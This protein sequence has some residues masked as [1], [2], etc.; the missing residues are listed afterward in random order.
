MLFTSFIYFTIYC[1]C[2][3]FI[4][5]VSLACMFS[6]FFIYFS[7]FCYLF[8]FLLKMRGALLYKPVASSPLLTHLIFLIW[9]VRS[10][11]G[12]VC[13]QNKIK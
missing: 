8:A 7:R 1:F 12:R 2:C 11:T 4:N 9:T 10:I 13:K 5:H 3:I 6:F